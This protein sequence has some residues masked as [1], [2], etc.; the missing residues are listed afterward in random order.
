MRVET[1]NCLDILGIDSKKKSEDG[2]FFSKR[3]DEPVKLMM[4]T[5]TRQRCTQTPST[6]LGVRSGRGVSL[7]P[8]IQQGRV[9]AASISGEWRR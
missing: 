7:D 2:L 9:L 1:P 5:G 3:E 6:R 4:R 8:E